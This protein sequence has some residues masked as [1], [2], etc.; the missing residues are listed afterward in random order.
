MHIIS[1]L[2]DE[3]TPL[4]RVKFDGE[5]SDLNCTRTS[6]DINREYFESN[7]S[8]IDSTFIG[9]E[10]N[11]VECANCS[12][13]SVTYKPYSVM[14]LELTDSLE[15]SI[16]EYF[17]TKSLGKGNEYRC[18]SCKEKSEAKVIEEILSLPNILVFHLK[19]FDS[20]GKKKHDNVQYELTLNM[21]EH[22]LEGNESA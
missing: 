10:K 16:T 22:L 11:I 21:S 5:V 3:T 13:Q 4:N 6:N 17:Q 14:S 19:R 7:P 9:I 12:Y 20:R 1:S 18:D 15:N 8:I 2:Q